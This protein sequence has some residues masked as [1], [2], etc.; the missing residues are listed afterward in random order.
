MKIIPNRNWVQL[1][2]TLGAH[3][4]WETTGVEGNQKKKKKAQIL[5]IAKQSQLCD[6]NRLLSIHIYFSSIPKSG[7]Q[8][9]RFRGL[10]RAAPSLFYRLAQIQRAV[11]PT[12]IKKPALKHKIRFFFLF[13]LPACKCQFFFFLFCFLA[14][15][16]I[17]SRGQWHRKK[18]KKKRLG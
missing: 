13:F 11:E 15:D 5:C 14:D 7:Q 18:L 3:R 4:R 16:S 12:T 2:S 10:I 17:V 8:S 1:L 6:R 9:D